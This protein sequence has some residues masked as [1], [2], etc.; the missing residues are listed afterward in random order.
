MDE[1][2][3]KAVLLDVLEK[4]YL[5]KK[6]YLNLSEDTR[7]EK[8]FGISGDDYWE[9][10]EKLNVALDNKMHMAKYN[11]FFLPE[12]SNLFVEVLLLFTGKKSNPPVDPSINEL[13]KI[14]SEDIQG[15]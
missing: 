4:E 12:A 14:I 10:L 13:V 8:D 2:R 15:K 5:S 6:D 7:L 9:L 11:G 3:V 1:N